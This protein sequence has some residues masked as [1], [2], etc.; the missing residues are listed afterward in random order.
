MHKTNA[1]YEA[2]GKPDPE[3]IQRVGAMV[4]GLIQAGILKGGDGLGPSAQGARVRVGRGGATVAKGPFR[5]GAVPARYAMYRAGTV[6]EAADLGARFGKIFGEATVDVRPVNEAWD[7]GF[8]PKPEGLTTRRYMAV[9][10]ADAASEAGQPAGAERQAA[11]QGFR[12]DLEKSGAF[13]GLE[14]F[15]PS[16]KAKRLSASEGKKKIAVLDGPFT[17]TKELI[18]G[19]VIVELASIEEAVPWARQYLEQ[20]DT[21]EVDI[22]GLAED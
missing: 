12:Q 15:E 4:G 20:V 3:L 17:E 22:R 2:G 11:L 1:H 13:L 18:G 10:Q 9:V 5:G 16:K 21:E 14:R 19:F 8:A 6:D 7:L